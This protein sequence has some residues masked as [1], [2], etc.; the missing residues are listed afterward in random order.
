MG[1]LPF[2]RGGAGAAGA[3]SADA[4]VATGATA[5]TAAS[6]ASAFAGS[7]ASLSTSASAWRVSAS[8]LAGTARAPLSPFAT[9]PRPQPERGQRG[10]EPAREPDRLRRLLERLT[11][12]VLAGGDDLAGEFGVRVVA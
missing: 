9:S 7:E 6:A 11:D 2:V 5:G 12:G 1:R 10:M 4:A 3:A 8:A